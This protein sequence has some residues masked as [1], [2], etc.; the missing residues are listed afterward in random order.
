MTTIEVELGNGAVALQSL[1]DPQMR[2]EVGIEVV[3]HT[4][5]GMVFRMTAERARALIDTFQSNHGFGWAHD[6]PGA[7]K[8]AADSARNRIAAALAKAGA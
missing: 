1:D 6:N 8:R 4:K 3:R 7:E 5:R 2:R